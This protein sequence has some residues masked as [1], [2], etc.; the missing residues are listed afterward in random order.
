MTDNTNRRRIIII[1]VAVVGVCLVGIVVLVALGIFGAA[2]AVNN[3]P[4]V[5]P[6]P[7]S[8]PEGGVEPTSRIPTS[9]PIETSGPTDPDSPD[10]VVTA[11]PNAICDCSAN[12]LDC[13][14]FQTPDDA[15]ECYEYCGRVTGVDVHLLDIDADRIV[16]ET[17]FGNWYT[18]S[19][20]RTA[21]RRPLPTPTP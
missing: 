17:I 21:T 11:D 6:P 16:C 13:E 19:I 18:P 15:Q 14:D 10:G 4:T 5:T 2:A 9:A 20:P 1:I 3:L 12:T 7:V 8:T